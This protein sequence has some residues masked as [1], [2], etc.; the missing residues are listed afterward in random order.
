MACLRRDNGAMSYGG[1]GSCSL[2]AAFDKTHLSKIISIY[3]SITNRTTIEKTRR[4][5][6]ATIECVH[7]KSGRTG[8]WLALCV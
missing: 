7:G 4:A 3:L 2:L 6:L 8:G 5:N 1:I